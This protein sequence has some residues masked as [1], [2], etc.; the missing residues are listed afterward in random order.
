VPDLFDLAPEAQ[1]VLAEACDWLSD[2]L[3]RA[4]APARHL[5]QSARHCG[6]SRTTLHRAKRMLAVRSLKT[7]A[8]WLWTLPQTAP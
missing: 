2:A 6:I 4:P 7:A 3:A 8:G 1:S 5:L